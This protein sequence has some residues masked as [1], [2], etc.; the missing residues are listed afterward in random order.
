MSYHGKRFYRLDLGVIHEPMPCPEHAKTTETRDAGYE[1][2]CDACE[3]T[4]ERPVPVT[5]LAG[6]WVEVLNPDLLPYGRKKELYP[7]LSPL[8]TGDDIQARREGIVAG[9]I[10]AWNL[11]PVDLADG[12]KPEV[13]PL[14]RDD[15]SALDRAPDILSYVLAGLNRAQRRGEQ[16]VPKASATP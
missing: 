5:H 6:Y 2:G 4:P 13:L 7:P 14:P 15:R 9:L 8:A 11:E 1:T 10:T 12:E 3:K 16:A